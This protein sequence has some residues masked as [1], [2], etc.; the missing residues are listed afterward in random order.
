M[1]YLILL[2]II[3]W[4]IRS[5]RLIKTNE[6]PEGGIDEEEKKEEEKQP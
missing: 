1:E 6:Y 4:L 3:V 5:I 2:A